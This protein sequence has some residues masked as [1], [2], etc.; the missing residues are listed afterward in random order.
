MNS[1]DLTPRPFQFPPEIDP[2]SEIDP[3]IV[4]GIAKAIEIVAAQAG[5]SVEE[6]ICRMLKEERKA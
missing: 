5:I 1:D 6:L 2:E 4:E 3:E